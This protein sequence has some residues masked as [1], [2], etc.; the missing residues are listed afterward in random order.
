MIIVHLSWLWCS[1]KI[2]HSAFRCPTGFP[3]VPRGVLLMGMQRA[4]KPET[5]SAPLLLCLLHC[6]RWFT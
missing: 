5:A 4:K 2:W 3:L 6:L 1:H